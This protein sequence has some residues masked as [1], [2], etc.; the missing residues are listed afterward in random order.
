MTEAGIQVPG[1]ATLR[2]VIERGSATDIN[3]GIKDYREELGQL[4]RLVGGGA[5]SMPPAL[6]RQ[7]ESLWVEAVA[8]ARDGL[9]DDVAA[10]TMQLEAAQGAVQAALAERDGARST[11]MERMAEI[12]RLKGELATAH[13]RTEAEKEAREQ[14]AALYERQTQDMHLQQ[15]RLELMTREAAQER[16][17]ALKRLEGAQQHALMQIEEARSQAK[18]DLAALQ[19]QGQ[20]EKS[21][22]EM[23]LARTKAQLA[24]ERTG[25]A[26]AEQEASVASNLNAE[27]RDRL[28]RAER[29]AD[30]LTRAASASAPAP[31]ESPRRGR[32]TKLKPSVKPRTRMLTKRR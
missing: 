5:L 24:E 3:K 2:D 21:T 32:S 19:A 15:E 18:R 10:W 22:L 7:V 23:D 1:W 9:K 8:A 30:E 26:R 6:A 17:A 13:A 25:R 31:D 27:L 28:A 20:R 12:E 29:Q 16:E 14:L 4:L 11:A